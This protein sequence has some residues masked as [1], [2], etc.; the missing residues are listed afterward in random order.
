MQRTQVYLTDE[1]QDGL[2]MLARKTAQKKSSLIRLAIDHFLADEAAKNT[3][4]KQA[5]GDI[6]GIW[7][8]YEEIDELQS[9]VRKEFNR[10]APE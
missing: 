4:W 8:E 1:Q 2:S 10:Y 3:D 7:S 5:L 6:K 9:Q